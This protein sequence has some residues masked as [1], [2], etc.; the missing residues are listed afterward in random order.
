MGPLQKIEIAYNIYIMF[1]LVLGKILI[2]MLTL[3]FVGAIL[4]CTVWSFGMLFASSS[5]QSPHTTSAGNSENHF[6]AHSEVLAQ[7]TPTGASVFSSILLLMASFFAIVLFFSAVL[8]SS[9]LQARFRQL[10]IQLIQIRFLARR[11]I[12]SF[13][14]QFELSPSFA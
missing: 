12:I 1:K 13:L 5:H 10:L 9:I 6:I 4:S 3:V 14:T 7:L 8:N 11:K 2:A